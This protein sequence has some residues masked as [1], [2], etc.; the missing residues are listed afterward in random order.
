MNHS[1]SGKKLSIHSHTTLSAIISNI[2]EIM[3]LANFPNSF[4]NLSLDLPI[5]SH[6]YPFPVI[7]ILINAEY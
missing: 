2:F 7:A 3:N 4:P 1:K 6:P 5:I